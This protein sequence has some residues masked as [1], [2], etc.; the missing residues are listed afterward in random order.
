MPRKI[1]VAAVFGWDPQNVP[2]VSDLPDAATMIA[3][4]LHAFAPTFMTNA[5]RIANF[6][7][8]RVAGQFGMLGDA[9]DDQLV[10]LVVEVG[11]SAADVEG[12]EAPQPVRLVDLEVEDDGG[13][14][15]SS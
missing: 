11:A 13:H 15:T 4:P 1:N 10:Q 2:F 5:Q 3:D 8:G 14:A 7:L 6:T 12:A 9:L